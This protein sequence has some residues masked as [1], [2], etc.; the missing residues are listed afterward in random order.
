MD[1]TSSRARKLG[2]GFSSTTLDDD[3]LASYWSTNVQPTPDA[4]K[5]YLG[6]SL[7][8][9]YAFSWEV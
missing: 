2:K 7:T 6:L 1:Q 8:N 3:S 5:L 4:A 9:V